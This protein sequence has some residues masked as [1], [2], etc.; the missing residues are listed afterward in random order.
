L[1]DAFGQALAQQTFGEVV[2]HRLRAVDLA[3]ADG[4]GLEPETI[5]VTD[6]GLVIG[7]GPA[8]LR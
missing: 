6:S 3:L 5:T 7:F 8:P 4:M 2:V 1:L